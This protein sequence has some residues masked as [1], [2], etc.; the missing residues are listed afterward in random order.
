MVGGTALYQ[1]GIRL[2][3]QFICISADVPT[4]AD[5]HGLVDICLPSA[6]GAHDFRKEVPPPILLVVSKC[7][8]R[9]KKDERSDF[10]E[11]TICFL[12]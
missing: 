8:L 10:S 2:L 1:I 4:Y 9:D 11:R 12:L 5:K 6:K 7:A 3:F